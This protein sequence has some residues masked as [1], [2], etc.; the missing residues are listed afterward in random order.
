[1]ICSAVIGYCHDFLKNVDIAIFKGNLL[2][3][4]QT[5]SFIAVHKLSAQTAIRNTMNWVT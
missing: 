1:M 3:S 5:L 4:I 2:I